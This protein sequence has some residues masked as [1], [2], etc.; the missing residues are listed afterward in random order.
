MVSVRTL[1]RAAIVVLM[2]AGTGVW[3]ACADRAT[4]SPTGLAVAPD[5]RNAIAVQR[6]HTAALLDIPGVVGTAVGRL[7]DGRPAMQILLERPGIA[8]LPLALDGVPVS[9][10]VT[11]RF[12]AFSDPTQRQRP[13]PAGF[14]VGHPSITAGTI[15]AR[16]RD[17][18][19][20]VYILSNNH[21]LANSNGATIGD[22]EY[23]P[24]PFDGGTSADQIATL[25]DFQTINFT[26]GNNT[27][28]A[29]IAL[30]S[31][32][33]LDN[34]TPADEG[35]GMPNSTIYGDANGDGL[36]DDRNA[37]LGLNVQKYGRT[38]HR[39]HGQIT[40]VN[41]TVTVCYEASNFT[42]TKS[43]RYVD[44]LII[45]PGTFSGGGDSGSLIVTDDANLNPVALLFAGSSSVTIG[46]R[47]DLVLL[48]FGV[49]IDGFA[50]PPP[51]PLTDLAVTSI[52][53]PNPAVRGSTASISVMVKN[54]G[55]QDV[56]TFA[57]TLRDT[58]E[59]VTVGTQSVAGLVAGA[60]TTLTFAWTPDVVGNHDLVANHALADDQASNDQRS[61]TIPVDA[62]VTDVAVTSFAGPASVIVGHGI[63]I[64]VTVTN[65]GNL[66]VTSNF[67]VTLRD[68]TAGVTLGTQTVSGLAA[69]AGTTLVFGWNTT[70]A[71]LG[72]HR[73]LA[74]H[75]LTDDSAANNQLATVI[76][77]DPKPTDI[78]ATGITAPKS[79]N[80][81]DT[82]HVVVTV[83]NVGE[84][85]VGTP[86]A[87]ELTDGTADG[88]TVGTQTVTGLAVG[89]T[90]TVDIPWNTA[91]AA[92][93]GH[94]VIATQKLPDD[95]WTN[96]A[97]AIAINVD[98]A[99]PPT[100][101]PPPPPPPPSPADLA[102]TGITAPARVTQGDIAPVVVTVQN[103]G[104]LDVSANFDVVLTDG[105]NGVMIGTQTIP[106][107]AAGASATRTFNWNTAGV[108]LDGHTLFATQKLADNNSSNNSI[109]I[110]VIVNAP[111]T[112]DI[113]VSGV[114]APASVTQGSTA[115]IAVTVQNVGGLNVSASFDIVL[116][117][118][119]AGV[120]LGTQTVAGLGVGAN[121][122]R[123]FNWNTTS[124]ALGGH[125]L[126]ATQSLAD[127]NASNNQGSATI[128]VN[129]PSSDVAVTGLN[130]PG[131]VIRGSTATIGLTVQNVGGLNVTTSFNV[132]LTDA[133]AGVTLGTQTVSGLAIG[134]TAT[135]SFSWNTTG[136]AV[137]G[138]TLVATHSLTDDN[139]ANNQR[140]ATVTVTTPPAD[141]AL[142][143]ITAPGSVT[144]GDT[145]PV[146][147]TVQNVG[148]QDVTT[149]FDVVLTD[150]TAGNAV[151][152]TQTIPGLAAGASA[153][154]TFNW[155]TA[156]VATNGHILTA[157]QKF[158]DNN[159]SNNARAIAVTVNPPNL[160]V[161]NLDGVA[162]SGV[163]TWSATVRITAHDWKHN[164]LNGVTVRGSWNS[165]PEVQCVTT[166]TDGGGAGTCTLTLSSIPNATRMAY[167][168]MTGMTLSGYTYKS[169]ANHDPDGSSNGYSIFVKH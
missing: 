78:A 36:F 1:T 71:A 15:G 80:Q 38:T 88:V 34:A 140:S 81:G 30:S 69:G 43:A 128:T 65:V 84:V 19:G 102:L 62:P 27:M 131:S 146:V 138:H 48:R 152:G 159:S 44:Q 67:S 90:T 24:G 143:G 122:T 116:T 50:P 8:G 168:G 26:G 18:L 163:D 117:D 153:T 63:N 106:G 145:A 89:A 135:R 79:V 107:L 74:T 49:A 133:T 75:A 11:G 87:V 5:F 45:S 66:N 93:S 110:G 61:V 97:I 51:G 144:Q 130:A 2:A 161:G 33:M 141:L 92:I 91:G 142:T 60:S 109:G 98:S 124:A 28:D 83:K 120:T 86:F 9:Q 125:T 85:D 118:A 73:L 31:T 52:S 53:G 158:P 96:D 114:T 41:A 111:P 58:T 151:L 166:D 99:V 32:A 164:P 101:P 47:I 115:A 160:H 10:R 94:I 157:T 54:V 167:F 149:N 46:N 59:H 68:T 127:A 136:A 64:G 70:G 39:T 112:T 12:M 23:Q 82:A 148:G 14:S 123:T 21:V 119:T 35:Y 108:A 126:V 155:N 17:A 76:R 147:V 37:L 150:G 121:T 154:R 162:T 42:C 16:V 56:S 6:R 105:F 4:D 20:R 103:V 72:E 129:A 29:A 104:G 169:A 25:T 156:G 77:V 55:N 139:A 3:Y 40:G 95:K 57:V 100:P 113:A 165:G 13:A 22:P 137:G 7:P 134:A 132:V